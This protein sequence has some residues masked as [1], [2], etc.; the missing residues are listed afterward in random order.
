MTVFDVLRCTKR[1]MA[2]LGTV[3]VDGVVG[4]E[5]PLLPEFDDFENIDDFLSLDYEFPLLSVFR[6]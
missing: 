3:V 6:L 4:I 1:Q 2:L 5:L